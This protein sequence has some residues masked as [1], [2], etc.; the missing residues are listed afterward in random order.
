MKKHPHL[1]LVTEAVLDEPRALIVWPSDEDTEAF[2]ILCDLVHDQGYTV[3]NAQ[4]EMPTDEI[5]LANH[6]GFLAIATTVVL[7]GTWWTSA[8]A[9]Q[10]VTIAGWLGL[11]FVDDNCEP[12]PVVG[13]RVPT[14]A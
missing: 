5:P 6:L 8:S 11:E 13:Q 2:D 7:P 1:R 3:L 4:D 14:N 9:H 12:I 10:I